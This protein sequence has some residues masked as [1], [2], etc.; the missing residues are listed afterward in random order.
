MKEKAK[1]ILEQNIE[2]LNSIHNIVEFF[3][4]HKNLK[5]Y[6]NSFNLGNN[7]SYEYFH[8][9]FIRSKKYNDC[10]DFTI[11]NH[12]HRKLVFEEVEYK[13][14]LKTLILVL[15]N[16]YKLKDFEN[17]KDFDFRIVKHK[18]ERGNY[19]NCNNDKCVCNIA[20]L[21][22]DEAKFRL[23]EFILSNEKTGQETQVELYTGYKDSKGNKIYAGDTVSAGGTISVIDF[24]E[25]EFIPRDTY[26]ARKI[27]GLDEYLNHTPCIV[28]GNIHENKDLIDFKKYQ[29]A[30]QK[31][32]TFLQQKTFLREQL[33]DED[34]ERIMDSCMKDM[35][36]KK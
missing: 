18:N 13:E 1:I 36:K 24:E 28:L 22:G 32:Q 17:L 5:I 10:L 9:S 14:I 6:E 29:K 21:Y 23:D 25:A 2:L 4:K 31:Q 33:S 3:K 30:L 15:I 34:I 27:T 19:A 8:L 20:F 35:K 16:I 7:E 12:T 26:S 11:N